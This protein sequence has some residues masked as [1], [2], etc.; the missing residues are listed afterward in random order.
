MLKLT[1]CILWHISIGA[2]VVCFSAV[3]GGLSGSENGEIGSIPLIRGSEML[4]EAE[5]EGED[6]C[7][8]GCFCAEGVMTCKE[9][10]RITKLENLE[11]A[12]SIVRM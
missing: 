6:D 2:V 5:E 3:N 1:H 10:G 7:Y 12:A 9:F 8:E 11:N 4:A